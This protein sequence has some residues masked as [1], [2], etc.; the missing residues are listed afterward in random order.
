MNYTLVTRCNCGCD[1]SDTIEVSAQTAQSALKLLRSQWEEEERDVEI[2]AIFEGT[3]QPLP[4]VS[5]L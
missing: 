5:Q 4:M 3:P 2:L 1:T